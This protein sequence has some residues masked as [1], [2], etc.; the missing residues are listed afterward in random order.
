ML[1]GKP[2]LV[3]EDDEASAFYLEEILT[4]INFTVTTATNAAE[5]IELIHQENYCLI[6]M[7]IRLPDVD[8]YELT[9]QFRNNGIT[10]PIIAQTAFVLPHD[11]EKAI[12]CGC[13]DYIAKPIRKEVLFEILSRYLGIN[14]RS[15]K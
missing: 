3:I 8:G 1:N 11:R 2:I 15:K 4:E 12:S 14:I 13:N 9:K 5:A 6:L 7:D 10:I